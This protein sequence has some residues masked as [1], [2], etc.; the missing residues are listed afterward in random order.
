[1]AETSYIFRNE[2]R[3]TLPAGAYKIT[4]TWSVSV[5]NTKQAGKAQTSDFFV[6]GERFSLKPA[7]IHSAYPPEGSRGSY[8]DCLPH[9]ALARDTLPWERAANGDKTPWLALLALHE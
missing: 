7:D 1:M 9:V 8:D 5:G 2:H 6:A 3:P 4:S